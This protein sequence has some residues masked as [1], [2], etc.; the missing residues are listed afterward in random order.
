MS[1]PGP[2]TQ[3]E[4]R[5]SLAALAGCSL[6]PPRDQR[7]SRV[8]RGPTRSLHCAKLSEIEALLSL[9]LTTARSGFISPLKSPT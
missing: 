9:R 2:S 5:G 3:V 4:P 6:P 8:L 7:V 1:L